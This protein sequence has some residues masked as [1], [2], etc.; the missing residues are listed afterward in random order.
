MR[1][2]CEFRVNEK[3]AGRL[4]SP[5]EGTRLGDSVRKVEIA[6]NDPRYK[7]VGELDA[8]I[9]EKEGKSFFF[10]WGIR[11][12]YSKEEIKSADLF[13][14]IIT[15]VFEPAGEECGTK[16]DESKV[17]KRCG[18][19]RRQIGDLVLD[20]RRVPRG[21]D[22]ARTI[23]DE[24]IVSQRLAEYLLDAKL[25][26]FQLRPVR[27]KARYEDDAIKLVNYPS[28]RKLLEKARAVGASHPTWKFYVWA[29]RPEQD[30]LWK[31]VWKEHAD[32]MQKK[33]ASRP[34]GQLPTWYQ[35]V[36]TSRPVS[37][38]TPTLFGNDPFDE[39]PEGKYCCSLGHVS[40][41]NL[42]S[43]VWV[44]RAV[45]DGSDIVY[46][47]DLVGTRRGLLVPRPMLLISPRFRRMLVEKDIK[48][49]KVEVA[50]LI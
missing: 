33:G 6:T 5:N 22:I 37:T 9:Q 15:A 31:M 14:L 46:T 42:L 20:L 2:T 10:G 18:A 30:E 40:G 43:E 27:H 47:K 34:R 23:A 38:V 8:E 11:H 32:T 19:G 50:H 24:W 3:Y 35:I 7:Q 26:G 36:V 45:W 4:F 1:T 41:L 21:K 49:Y 29:N 25:T 12:Y 44:K 13:H 48:G 39:D 28:G 16:Y 17:C